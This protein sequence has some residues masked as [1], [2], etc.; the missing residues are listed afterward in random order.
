MN[1]YICYLINLIFILIYRMI[2]RNKTFRV[3]GEIQTQDT[4]DIHTQDINMQNVYTRQMQ[5]DVDSDSDLQSGIV[6]E[7][8]LS[9]QLLSPTTKA[10]QSQKS[11]YRLNN[12]T[13]S[14]QRKT[15]ARA[16]GASHKS[17]QFLSKG[18]IGK[19]Q[20]LGQIQRRKQ[21]GSKCTI[22]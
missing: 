4:Q 17:S 16:T 22:T 13:T 19:R 15:I 9:S 5:N 6:E 21:N 10:E 3:P 8:S 12:P 7:V 11:E 1:I 14:S 18:K 2:S 20:T